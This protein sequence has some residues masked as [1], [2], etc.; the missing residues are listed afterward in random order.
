M[1]IENISGGRAEGRESK[2]RAR[3]KAFLTNSFDISQLSHSEKW[4]STVKTVSL[5]QQE[6]RVKR[7]E[8]TRREERKKMWG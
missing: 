3:K 8:I 4:C 2:K 6:K 5:L 7:E 1:K